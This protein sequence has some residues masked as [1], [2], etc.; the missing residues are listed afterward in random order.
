MLFPVAVKDTSGFYEIFEQFVP[1]H[2]FMVSSL[3]CVLADSRGGFSDSCIILYASRMFCSN[4]YRDLPWLNT[5]GT[6]FNLPTNHSSSCQYSKVKFL[7]IQRS[8]RA[9]R[10]I[11][12]QKSY[13]S[14]AYQNSYCLRAVRRVFL[15]FLDDV[16]FRSLD[17]FGILFFTISHRTCMSMPKYS[18][19]R[20]SR[21]PE[22]FRYSIS[23]YCFL[24]SVEMCF[25]ASPIISRLR[26]T[27][28]ITS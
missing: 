7:F 26:T 28:S 4:S 13:V 9:A 23:G 20:I 25:A 8:F 19:I 3:L 11:I 22:I 17:S 5:P 12:I 24:I 6:S 14:T 1:F 27:P 16:F 2:T 10:I 18:W 21:K 15:Y